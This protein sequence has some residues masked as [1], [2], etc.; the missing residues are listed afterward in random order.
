MLTTKSMTRQLIEFSVPLVLSGLLQQLFSWADAFIVGNI[1]GEGALA[2]VGATMYIT[3]LYLAAVTGF[4][5]G[6]SILSAQMF[7]QGRH[8]E[9]KKVLY[10]FL[11]VLGGVFLLTTGAGLYLVEPILQWMDTPADIFNMAQEY[12]WIVMWGVPFLTLYNVYAAV[13]RGIGD[14]RSPTVAVMVSVSVNVALDIL[15]V[16]V[17]PMGIA[18][19]AIATVVSQVMMALFLVVYA[20]MRHPE[21]GLVGGKYLF[22]AG[23]LRDGCRLAVPIT[24]QSLICS[25]G[26]LTLGAFMNGFGSQTV[27]AIST[28][29]RVDSVILLPVFNLGTGISTLAAQNTGAGEHQKARRFLYVGSALMAV[30]CVVLSALMVVAGA[31][32]VALF[33][34]TEEVSAIGG[35]FFR[36][37]CVFYVIYGWATAL[38]GYLEG[39]SD[40]VFTG[41]VGVL[42]LGVRVVLSYAL[43]D[44]VGNMV[45]AYAEGLSWC[46]TF[47]LLA[48]RFMTLKRV[49][50]ARDKTL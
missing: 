31:P 23:L 4:T 16:G 44:A 25:V 48:L 41:V 7:G 14:S 3:A 13:L 50:L 27:A 10:T 47:V 21:L 39:V 29:Y 24:V 45:I 11:M 28:A 18:G 12:L 35:Q 8:E 22:D 1:L 49:P 40:V 6:V 32:L 43:M 37:I 46:F 26:G 20:G 33:G 9:Q 17:I 38:R 2:A 34:V 5:S 15:L 30:V 36:C 42:S 19:A